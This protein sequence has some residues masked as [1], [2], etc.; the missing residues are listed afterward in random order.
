MLNQT[1]R[2]CVRFARRR[3]RTC[4]P[5]AGRVSTAVSL[6]QLL[7]DPL[8]E[9]SVVGRSRDLS[10]L[11]GD[12]L[13]PTR[14]QRAATAPDARPFVRC[15]LV[16]PLAAE[17][18]AAGWVAGGRGSCPRARSPPCMPAECL[19]THLP[20]HVPAPPGVRARTANGTCVPVA[21]STR[22][23]VVYRS[24]AVP[25]CRCAAASTAR[26]GRLAAE[27]AT[28]STH[29]A[30]GSGARTL[31]AGSGSGFRCRL[32]AAPAASSCGAHS[33]RFVRFSVFA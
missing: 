19:D 8:L 12:E 28:H 2:C 5:F 6:P 30:C 26:G 10:H 29:T 22:P 15:P 21:T 16:A 27:R 20:E 11:L 33:V 1:A 14:S 31:R 13:H 4:L 24:T 3:A 32:H 7:A 18:L 25:L 17:P 9:A 23:A